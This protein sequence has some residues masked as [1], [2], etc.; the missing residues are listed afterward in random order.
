M[1]WKVITAILA[2][3]SLSALA[4]IKGID[5]AILATSC[6]LIAGLAGYTIGKKTSS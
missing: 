3:T 6:T 2:I 1:P 5:G 4:L